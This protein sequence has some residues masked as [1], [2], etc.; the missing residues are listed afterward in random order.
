MCTSHLFIFIFILVAVALKFDFYV[1]YS[2]CGVV[3]GVLG[4]R[5]LEMERYSLILRA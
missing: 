5:S 4:I 1:N 2:V 3:G